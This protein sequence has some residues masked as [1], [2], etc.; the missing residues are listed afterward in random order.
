MFCHCAK[1]GYFLK[2]YH[3]FHK[4]EGERFPRLPAWLVRP[5]QPRTRVWEQPGD[6]G[7]AA[8]QSHPSEADQVPSPLPPKCPF[9]TR[10]AFQGTG[11]PFLKGSNRAPLSFL[12]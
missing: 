7:G 3:F 8:A 10:P 9:L 2:P 6:R 4:K 12:L 11:N 1:L 5:Q